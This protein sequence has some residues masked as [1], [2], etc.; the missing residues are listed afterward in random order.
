MAVRVGVIGAGKWGVNHLR[1]YSSLPCT[2]VGISDVDPKKKELADQYKTQ[3][4]TDY[5][6]LLSLVDAVSVVVP[7]DLHYSVVKECLNAGKHVL[8]EKPIT[9]DSKQARELV[10][11][12]K[13]KK[14]L[15]MVG[16]LFRFNNAVL[17][18]KKRL[19]QI[20]K[21]QYIT[22]RY[23]HSSKPPRKDSGVIFN[24]GVHMVDT[25]TYILERRPKKVFAKKVHYLSKEREDFA[26]LVLD[27]GDFVASIEVSCLHPEKARDLWIIGEK[28]K[29]YADLLEQKILVH[30]LSVSY[31]KI[32]RGETQE[33]ALKPNEPLT[34]ELQHFLDCIAKK[35]FVH[36][37]SIAW[38]EYL[39]TRLCE[40]CIESAKTG[41]QIEVID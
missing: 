4:F 13:S 9:L 17:A 33:I 36:E 40:L 30:P 15:L 8:V 37:H 22:A 5:K 2:L 7:T 23:I 39:T 24:L 11:L 27:Y 31:E 25:L 38:D 18:M 20:G 41:E 21:V 19:N 16:Y 28:E 10:E 1:A 32:D 12:A 14:L 29:V 35:N 6:K 3:F 26:L 34:D